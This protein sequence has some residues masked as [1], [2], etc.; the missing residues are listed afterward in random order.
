MGSQDLF[1]PGMDV[2]SDHYSMSIPFNFWDLFLNVSSPEKLHQTAMPE[3]SVKIC[4]DFSCWPESERS[5]RIAKNDQSSTHPNHPNH[6]IA[7]AAIAYR[8]TC[9]PDWEGHPSS[10]RSNLRE[11]TAITAP[12]GED[13]KKWRNHLATTNSSPWKI[14]MLFS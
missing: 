2:R 13:P 10:H 11:V 3:W 1:K 5:A 6:P 12:W 7:I 14:T 8:K 4:Q 9:A